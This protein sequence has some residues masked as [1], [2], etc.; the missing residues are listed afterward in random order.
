MVETVFLSIWLIYFTQ[1]IYYIQFVLVDL[2]LFDTFVELL[3]TLFAWENC[4][5]K[6]Y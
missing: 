3:V 5:E 6:I 2:F 1:N 4:S